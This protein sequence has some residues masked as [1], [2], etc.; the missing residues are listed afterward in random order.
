M[1]NVYA[2]EDKLMKVETKF[3]KIYPNALILNAMKFQG[4]NKF[5][6]D[7]LNSSKKIQFKR[8]WDWVHE[9][10]SLKQYVEL[11]FQKTTFLTDK[12]QLLTP[13]RK[14]GTTMYTKQIS[15]CRTRCIKCNAKLKF[16]SNDSQGG[17]EGLL[18]TEDT[19]HPVL[20]VLFRYKYC[21]SDKCKI[22]YAHAF[23]DITE[24]TNSTNSTNSNNANGILHYHQNIRRYANVYYVLCIDK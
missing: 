21:S 5:K 4:C 23:Y 12:L 16:Q 22:R 15:T 8:F 20:P 1:G 18:Y 17:T 19:T 24:T 9:T 11:C 2:L 13:K 10:E 7:C 14:P 3:A 6:S